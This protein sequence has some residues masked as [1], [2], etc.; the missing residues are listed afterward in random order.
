MTSQ[1][2]SPQPLPV[3]MDLNQSCHCVPMDRANIIDTI[4]QTGGCDGM[5]AMLSARENYFANS[6]V[7]ISEADMAAMKAQIRAIESVFA[8][9]EYQSK[10]FRGA[11][12][13]V[14][15]SQTGTKGV[16]MG[17]DFHMT[18]EGPRLI[19]I[20]SNAGGAFIVSAL[21]KAA[22]RA[23]G[24][25]TED[26]ITMFEQEWTLAGREAPLGTIAIV[27]ENPQEQFHYP[28]MCL[29]AAQLRARGYDVVIADPAE[30]RRDGD[31]LV[32]GEMI[33]DL[34][35]NR[36]TDFALTDPKNAVLRQAL[37]NDHAV[38]TPAPRHHALY[39]DKRNLTLLSDPDRLREMGIKPEDRDVLASI[40][41]TVCVTPENMDSL[42]R[43]RRHYFFKPH[44]G[45]GSRAA[46]RGAKLTKK[47]WKHIT[48]HNYVAQEFV[49]PSIRTI[50][51][52]D[53]P[54]VL[55][56]DVRLYSY[57]G[58]SFL[59]AARVYQGQTTNL[60]T[61]GGG[62]AP[63]ITIGSTGFDCRL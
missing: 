50:L 42:W 39:A 23:T 53:E 7:F 49:S 22:G 56:F 14:Y 13:P 3:Q 52:E 32:L 41:K 6:A 37:L 11:D 29:A 54:A 34:I 21:D 43:D 46:Y 33:I 1:T 17:Y 63:V 45:F 10:I 12:D 35:Y 47:V 62:L 55:K 58:V 16:F 19:E 2:S 25:T 51:R 20:N 31:R 59:T 27:D 30:L 5:G 38:I 48:S 28:D 61:E 18:P 24:Q 15:H 9:P 4:R 8:T 36:L 44:A 40:P 26:I 60:R 57:D